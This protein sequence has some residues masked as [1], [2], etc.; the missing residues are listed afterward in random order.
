MSQSIA[1][2]HRFILNR[3]T[4]KGHVNVTELSEKLSVSVVTIRKDLKWL[5]SKGLLNRT[6]GSA[7]P[8]IPFAFDRHIGDKE[9]LRVEQ[10]VA[11][12][13]EAVKILQPND[14]ILLAS[15]STILEFARQ[16]P[17]LNGLTVVSASLNASQAITLRSNVEIIQ[18][19]GMVRRSSSSV[20]GPFA[21]RMLT[22]LNCSILF[23]GA[24]GIDPEYGITTTNALEA[25]L[26]R[27]MM[28]ASSRVVVLADSSKFGRRGFGK[29][30]AANEVH[31][32]ITDSELPYSYKTELEELG[33][34]VIIAR[35]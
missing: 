6:H 12:A 35:V 16:I 27:Q 33:V 10:K 32:I 29:I 5:E 7:S 19:G 23:M 34:E 9:K 28:E 24:D 3:L 30:C 14:S 26:N 22:N 17:D 8:A 31:L 13:R 21:E 2:R 4:E 1:E 15:G 18:L 25:S 20:L 11:I